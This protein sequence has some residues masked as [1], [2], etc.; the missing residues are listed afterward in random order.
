MFVPKTNKNAI[1]KHVNY[2]VFGLVSGYTWTSSN[3]TSERTGWWKR[4][5]RQASNLLVTRLPI[6]ILLNEST[7][8]VGIKKE[9]SSLNILIDMKL[10]SFAKFWN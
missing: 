5:Q 10:K 8:K 1:Q 3:I 6:R 7:G 4:L 2:G 9:E